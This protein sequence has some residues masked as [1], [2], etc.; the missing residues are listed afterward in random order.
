MKLSQ[1]KRTC[2]L[3]GERREKVAGTILLKMRPAKEEQG[4]KPEGFKGVSAH[5]AAMGSNG[6]GRVLLGGLKGSDIEASFP[7]A[8]SGCSV[9]PN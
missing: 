3:F 5:C 6:G 9:W 4:F 2:R 7:E 8:R 1:E